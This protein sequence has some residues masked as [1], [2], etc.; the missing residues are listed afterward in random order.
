MTS[1]Q[2]KQRRK[3][4][5]K[6]D[7]HAGTPSTLDR[8]EE[9][10]VREEQ[11]IDAAITHEVIRRE[12]VKELNRSPFGLAWSGLAAGL[13]MGL[14]TLTIAVLHHGLPETTWRH[15]VTAFGYP[16]GFLAVTLG[17]QQLYTENTLRPVVPFMATPTRD[18]LRKTMVLWSVVLATNL[19][20]AFLFAWAAARTAIFSPELRH[21][22][23]TLALES[24]SHD[25][26]TVF[27]TG[28]VAG[29]I[30]A[31]MVWM[32]PAASTSQIALVVI[33]TWIIGAAKLSHVIVGAVEAFYLTA[34]GDMGIGAALGGYVLPAFLGNT[35]GG[36]A[37]VAALNHAQVEPG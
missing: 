24:M 5:E 23:R 37:L 17:S 18:M 20:G 22:M 10:K 13:A 2:E 9:H 28:I 33:M 14:S 26:S 16:I 11:K 35:L 32:L 4:E 12:A 21:A 30:I 36:V 3:A 15:L 19:V 27:A 25:W 31:L 29:W 6:H 8:Q 7:E 1:E 34:L